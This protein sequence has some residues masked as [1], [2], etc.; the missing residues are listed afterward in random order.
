MDTGVH[1]PAVH[2]QLGHFVGELIGDILTAFQLHPAAVQHVVVL[3][4]LL[5]KGFQLLPDLGNALFALVHA[6]PDLGNAALLL[7]N[8]AE[9]ALHTLG[10]AFH[11]GP[12][13][14]GGGIA[15]SGGGFGGFSGGGHGGGGGGIR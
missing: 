8:V 4:C 2:R 6:A 11:I 5:L 15:F 10:A 9:H 7:G 13:H 1:A 14:R 12:Q 3:F